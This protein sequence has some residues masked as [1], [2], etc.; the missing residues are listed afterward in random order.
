MILII[1]AL[2]LPLTLAGKLSMTIQHRLFPFQWYL[3]N[4]TTSVI[5]NIKNKIRC[6]SRPSQRNFRLTRTISLLLPEGR[7]SFLTA[8]TAVHIKKD[9]TLFTSNPVREEEGSNLYILWLADNHLLCCQLS[10][11]PEKQNRKVSVNRFCSII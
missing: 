9:Y 2:S 5:I 6:F 3:K 4:I 8:S 11:F 7:L 1:L 10:Y